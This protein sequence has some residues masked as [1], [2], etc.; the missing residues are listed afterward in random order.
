[1]LSTSTLYNALSLSSGFPQHLLHRVSLIIFLNPQFS[2]QFPFPLSILDLVSF[3]IETM[4]TYYQIGCIAATLLSLTTAAVTGQAAEVP[5]AAGRSLIRRLELNYVGCSDAQKSK[6]GVDF[7]DAAILGAIGFGIDR[8][9]TAY[10]TGD[11]W[12]RVPANDPRFTHYLRAEDGDLATSVMSMVA[13]N[14]DPTNTSYK[15]SVRCAA[16][17]DNHCGSGR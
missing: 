1:M 12:H 14:N 15:F 17:N 16:S 11:D 6:L 5:K 10:V 9:S 7:A 3:A 13:A 8:T 4:T 2:R